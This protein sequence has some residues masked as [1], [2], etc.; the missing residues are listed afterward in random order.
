MTAPLD[1]LL[2]LDMTRALAGPIAGRMLS[3]LGARVIKVEPPAGDLTRTT[4]PRH[5]SMAVYFV[6]ANVGKECISIDVTT[7]EGKDV[8]LQLVERADVVLENFRAGVLDRLGLGFDVLQSVNPTIILASVSGYGQGNSWSHRGAFAVAVQAETGLTADIAKRRNTTPANDPVSQSDVYGGMT[9]ATALL[10]A[11][12]Y[13][14]RTGRGQAIDV[15]MASATL[16]ANDMTATNVGDYGEVTDGFRAGSNWPR[17]YQLKTGRWV[18][19]SG[20]SA[21]PG[22]FRAFLRAMGQRELADDPRFD[23]M[24]A[25][26]AN[27]EALDAIIGEWVAGF[28]TAADVE[29]AIGVSTMLVADV[30]TASEIR[31]TPWAQ[32]RGAF[33]DVTLRD[34]ADPVSV[35]QSP[36]RFSESSAGARPIVGFRGEDNRRVLAELLGLSGEALD[37]LEESGAISDRVPPWRRD[38][39]A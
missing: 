8:F 3:D 33:L 11:L 17:C 25:R 13:R 26:M 7:P 34:G 10:A 23:T 29:A 16:F 2:V 36:W 22:A 27:A 21:V 15:D 14:N 1:D 39:T 6:Q 30:R 37:Q 35:P 4:K 38:A 31:D 20:D 12:H 18:V 9:A 19:I 5:E 28:E 32:E 24:E